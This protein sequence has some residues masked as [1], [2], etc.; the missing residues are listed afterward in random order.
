MPIKPVD[1]LVYVYYN[2][3]KCGG[4][5]DEM[6]IKEVMRA[7]AVHTCHFCGNVDEIEQVSRVSI[8]FD[9]G[10]K[11]TTQK[12]PTKFIGDNDKIF[13]KSML[14]NIGHPVRLAT[15]IIDR[16]VDEQNPETREQLFKLCVIELD[17]VTV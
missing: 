13:V 9:D 15:Q 6:R 17:E 10:P 11:K 14:Q 2:C 3:S 12:S 5:G 16:V 4:R 1:A 8:H 7:G